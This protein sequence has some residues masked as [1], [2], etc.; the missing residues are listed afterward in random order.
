MGNFF[1]PNWFHGMVSMLLFI[2]LCWTSKV[3]NSKIAKNLRLRKTRGSSGL[4]S[5]LLQKFLWQCLCRWP[6]RHC[7]STFDRKT[8]CFQIPIEHW[9]CF[10]HYETLAGV[11]GIVMHVELFIS[12]YCENNCSLKDI[13]LSRTSC[14]SFNTGHGFR[15]NILTWGLFRV[16]VSA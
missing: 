6:P 11:L 2:F 4:N 16:N 15:P 7:M 1:K 8:Q 5:C 12:V 14:K 9:E 13:W 3:A 10:Q